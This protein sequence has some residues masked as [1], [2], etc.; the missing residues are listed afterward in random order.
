[1]ESS[2][3]R[4]ARIVKTDH[5]L[6]HALLV[7]LDQKP[8]AQITIRDICAEAGIHYTTFFRHHASK[9]A[10]L[11]HVAAD[12]IDRLVELS[13]GV[14]DTVDTEASY[15]ALCRYVSEHRNLWTTLLTGGAAGAMRDEL[16]R[17]SRGVAAERTSKRREL[18]LDLA[19]NCA[20]SVIVETIFWWLNQPPRAYSVERVAGYLQQL[21]HGAVV[22][23]EE[24]PTGRAGRKS[25]AGSRT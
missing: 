8:L 1:M 10:L 5:A 18:P 13:L 15:L 6:R 20:V 25:R 17:V 12:Q 24:L 2:S 4:D 9:E 11:E 23:Q 21:L 16:L 19:T 3:A 7:L 14:R 22:E